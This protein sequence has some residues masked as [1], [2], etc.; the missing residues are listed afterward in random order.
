MML[1]M[2]KNA[3]LAVMFFLEL[4]VYL[5]VGYWGFTTGG[6]WPLRLLLGIGGPALMAGLW[7]FFGSPKATFPL[8]GAGRVLLEIG[9]FGAGVAAAA[10]AG[11]ITVSAVFA[12]VFAANALLR[13]LWHQI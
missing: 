4:G 13:I 6:N 5:A 2:A 10:A 11:L 12:A 3:N 8:R 1:T 7:A 9:W